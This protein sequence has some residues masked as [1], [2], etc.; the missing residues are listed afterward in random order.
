L[1]ADSVTPLATVAQFTEGAYAD[2]VRNYSTQS[3]LDAL[4]EATRECEGQAERRLAPFTKTESH[5]ATGVDPDE[6]AGSGNLPLDIYGQLGRSYAYSLGAMSLVR[7]V[8]LDEYA[9]RYPELWQ[10]SN[11]SITVDRSYGGSQIL[12]SGQFQQPDPDTGHV[13]I[14]LGVFVPIGSFIK[15]TYSGGYQT[16]PGD[17]SRACKYLAAAHIIDELDPKASTGHDSE[18]LRSRAA[19]ILVGYGRT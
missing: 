12:N 13:F 18:G 3:I 4:I 9:P 8:W 2:L 5:R 1:A 19:D 16:V 17:L 15:V 10:Y 11:V 7:H 14:S 6:Y